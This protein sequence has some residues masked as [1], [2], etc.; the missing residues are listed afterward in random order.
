MKTTPAI[1]RTPKAL[2]VFF[3]LLAFLLPQIIR[4]THHHRKPVHITLHVQDTLE[5]PGGHCLICSF[6][7]YLAE[8]CIYT[9]KPFEKYSFPQSIGYLPAIH[10][11]SCLPGQPFQRG[12]PLS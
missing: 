5:E 1:L 3:L 10:F 12:P 11:L 4:A 2:P 7:F 8:P 9:S 6:D